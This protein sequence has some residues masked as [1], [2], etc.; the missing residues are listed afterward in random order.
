MESS[1]LVEELICLCFQVSLPAK[2]AVA[3]HSLSKYPRSNESPFSV[4][5]VSSAELDAVSCALVIDIF[6]QIFRL[7]G[8][9][10]FYLEV[11]SSINQT[12]QLQAS[13]KFCS[14]NS[15]T[16]SMR[17]FY[18]GVCIQCQI[19]ISQLIFGKVHRLFQGL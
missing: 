12:G 16:T 8:E 7:S 15:L 6:S 1:L 14:Y 4:T 10:R 9:F 5:P 2:I 11:C 19:F 13:V 18:K 17:Y 3:D